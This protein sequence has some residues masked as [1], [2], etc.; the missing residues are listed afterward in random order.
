MPNFAKQITLKNGTVV[1]FADAALQASVASVEASS[2]ATAAHAAG[3]YLILDGQIYK[4]TDAIAIGDTIAVGTNVSATTVGAVL[5]SLSDALAANMSVD[6]SVAQS[7]PT[8]APASP[9]DTIYI[10]LVGNDDPES[11]NLYTEYIWV[12]SE[13][14]WEKLGGAAVDLS[15]YQET[16]IPGDNIT[17]AADGKTISSSHPT[18]TMGTDTTS[19][20]TISSGSTFTVIDSVTKDSNGHV[21]AVNVKTVTAGTIDTA[22]TSG[23]QNAVTSGA[24]YNA[25]ET[26]QAGVNITYDSATQGLV[27]GN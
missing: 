22:V 7:A 4:A 11:S 10:V 6:I 26:A 3:E 17:I 12:N 21:T 15:G 20:A 16:L 8:T 27:V 23:S 24:V 18:I 25:I 5:K 1:N 19:T 13:E 2:T 14:T 9:S